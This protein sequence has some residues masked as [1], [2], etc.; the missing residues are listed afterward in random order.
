[1]KG[2]EQMSES[3]QPLEARYAYYRRCQLVMRNGAQCR[4]PAM[5]G[6]EICRNHSEKRETAQRRRT[7]QLAVL[8][9][10]AEKISA[11]T[12]TQC[13]IEDVF[14]SRH[15]VQLALNEAMQ[16]LIDD[17]LDVKGARELLAELQV[18]LFAPAG[19]VRAIPS[20]GRA[21]TEPLRRLAIISMGMPY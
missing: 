2:S 13:A 3:G 4:C 15:G 5:K 6:A 17:R 20:G 12:G 19:I 8:Q 1:M 16:A 21:R 7:Q 9:R 10:A 11:D 18:A 14:L